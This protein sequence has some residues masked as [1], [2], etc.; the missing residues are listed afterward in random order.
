M[1]TDGRAVH[2]V[3][4]IPTDDAEQAM[5]TVAQRLGDRIRMLPDG[6]TGERRN[7]VVH[8]VESL[9][10]HPDLEV[11]R[12]GDWSDYDHAT[13]LKVR[14]HHRLRGDALDF[15]HVAA[16]DASLPVFSQIRAD[17]G[18]NDL[19]F[20]VGIPG[21]L[22]IALFTLGPVGAFRHRRAFMDATLREIHT[23]HGKAGSSVVFQLELPVE[24]VFVTQ[25][26]RLLRPAMATFLAR[27]V[28]RLARL[29]PQGARF[30]IHLCLGDLGNKALGRMWDAQLLV[31]L[32]NAILRSWPSGRPLEYV[33]AP[34][35][36]G[37]DPAPRDEAFYQP[38]SQLR[39]PAD[40]R[41]IAGFVHEASSA[42]EHRRILG[43]IEGQ[44]GCRVDVATA[45]GLGRRTPEAAAITMDRAAELV[46]DPV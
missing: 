28:R 32:A 44:L 3:G 45:C 46:H 2:L 13:R 29:S 36:A 31:V 39:L 35:A 40:V 26:P 7:W 41:F 24:L 11:A 27:G 25:M 4:S 8:I 33:H 42:D 15:G 21:D 6:E 22:D 30:G 18:L 9:R 34:L 23:I 12:Q 37:D 14:A 10:T 1:G 19:A 5:R 43:V 17:T 38:L 20:Q 16:F